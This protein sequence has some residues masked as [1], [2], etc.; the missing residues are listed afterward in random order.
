MRGAPVFFLVL[1]ALAGCG[2]TPPPQTDAGL[3]HER[4]LELNDS[5]RRAAVRGDLRRAAAHYAEALRLAEEVE[6]FHGIAVNALNLAAI[7][8]ALGET[9][10]AQRALDRITAAPGRF[11]SRYVADAA[12]RQAQLALQ[13][14]RLDGAEQWLARADSSCQPPACASA[15]ALLNLRGQ[16]LLARGSVEEA[17]GAAVRALAA[18]RAENNREEEANALRLDGRGAARAGDAAA[19]AARFESALEIDRQLARPHK[20]AQDLLAL[21]ETELGRANA[22][23]AREYAQR[24]LDVSRASGNRPQQEEAAR[25]LERAQ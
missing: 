20:I 22:G 4:L 24:A 18:S 12:G 2:A 7:W 13:A 3:R 6:D 10:L 15:T 23:L 11:E 16:L 25:L 19:A 5:G 8:Q 9:T 21:A 14:G 1:L 17:R